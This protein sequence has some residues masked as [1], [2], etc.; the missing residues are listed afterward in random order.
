PLS[1]RTRN[2]GRKMGAERWERIYFIFLP[3]FFRLPSGLVNSCNSCLSFLCSLRSL[4]L[5]CS[6][7]FLFIFL[8]PYFCLILLLSAFCAGIVFVS[9]LFVPLRLNSPAVSRVFSSLSFPKQL[10]SL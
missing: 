6:P 2:L 5:I 8:P 1:R 3:P 9:A 10:V 7:G 4:R